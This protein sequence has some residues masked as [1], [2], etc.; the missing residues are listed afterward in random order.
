MT[1]LTGYYGRSRVGPNL[2]GMLA[3]FERGNHRHPH[4][5]A[6]G[7]CSERHADL[8]AFYG[9]GEGVGRLDARAKGGDPTGDVLLSCA[10][11][12]V[13]SRLIPLEYYK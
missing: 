5:S 13:R 2:G 10:S 7:S 12:T 9:N 8:H 6:H 1:F 4:G 3:R 11:D